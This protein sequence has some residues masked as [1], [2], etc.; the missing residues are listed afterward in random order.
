MVPHLWVPQGTENIAEKALSM[1]RLFLLITFLLKYS[2]T[3]I[4]FGILNNPE[5][6]Y[7]L[8]EQVRRLLQIQFRCVEATAATHLQ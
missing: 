4:V 2:R 1:H 6:I 7:R 5:M 3:T 8:Q